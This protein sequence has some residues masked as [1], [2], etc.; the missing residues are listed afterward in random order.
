MCSKDA[1]LPP[2][3]WL[4]LQQHLTYHEQTEH[5]KTLEWFA[6]L[7]EAFPA[8]IEGQ[9]IQNL[10]MADPITIAAAAVAGAAATAALPA[11]VGVLGFTGAGIAAGSTA[12]SMM[13][14]SAIA[15][16]GGVAAG[17]VVAVLQSVGAA[18]VSA[19]TS[20]AGAAGGALLG[21]LS[22]LF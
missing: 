3:R 21:A 12:A 11:V 20:V 18:G 7:A 14:A 6:W 4:H 2:D 10:P 9:R 16:G 13:S 5:L 1:E 22:S 17:S 19:A 15:N 8:R